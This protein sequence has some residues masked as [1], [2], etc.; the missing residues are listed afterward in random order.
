MTTWKRCCIAEVTMSR[1][2]RYGW[3]IHVVLGKRR[4]QVADDR[5]KA[6]ATRAFRRIRDTLR[7]HN[8]RDGDMLD[9]AIR[10]GMEFR[11]EMWAAAAAAKITA[12]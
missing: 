12:S 5:S 6:V 8:H 7:S 10:T 1:D 11:R 4:W 3:T 9:V 2:T